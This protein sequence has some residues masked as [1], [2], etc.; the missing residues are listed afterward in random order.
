MKKQKIYLFF[1]LFG[2]IFVGFSCN[3]SDDN[4]NEYVASQSVQVSGFRL[5][6]NDSVLANLDSVFFSIDLDRGLIY[7]ADSLPVG[8][9]VSEGQ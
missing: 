3:S 8:T 7:N 6:S 2:L 4:Y 9:N 1:L 5:A